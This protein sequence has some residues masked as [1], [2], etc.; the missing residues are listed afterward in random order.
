MGLVALDEEKVDQG[1][2][3]GETGTEEEAA[4]RDTGL[5]LGPLVAGRY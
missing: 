2:G 1:A 4:G 3:T 5:A